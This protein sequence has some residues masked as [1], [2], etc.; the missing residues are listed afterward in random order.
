MLI[1]IIQYNPYFSVA[2]VVTSTQLDELWTRL[3]HGLSDI[4]QTGDTRNKSS[5][6]DDADN[7]C[8]HGDQMVSC[9]VMR[10]CFRDVII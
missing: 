9:D 7:L 2:P 5:L 10:T 1:V 3:Q 8:I 6:L 4:L